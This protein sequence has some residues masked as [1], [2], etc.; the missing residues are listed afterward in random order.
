MNSVEITF[1][2]SIKIWWSFVW[3]AWIIMLPFAFL[4]IPL[5]YWLMPYPKIGEPPMPIKPEQ[6]TG[7]IIKFFFIWL[8]MVVGMIILQSLAMK[9]MLKT[10]WSDFRLV[11]IDSEPKQ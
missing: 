3:R 2:R 8:T 9:W 7:F 10:K 5:M 1:K 11:A 6:M 4:L